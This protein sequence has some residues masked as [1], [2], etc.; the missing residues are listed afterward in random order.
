MT[1]QLITKVTKIN[2]KRFDLTE[3]DADMY[4]ALNKDKNDAVSEVITLLTNIQSGLVE[5]ARTHLINAE[6]IGNFIAK[7][8]QNTQETNND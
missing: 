3:I 6:T 1:I 7:L 2:N 5:E 4:S 8:S